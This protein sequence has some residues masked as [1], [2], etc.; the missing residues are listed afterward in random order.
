MNYNRNTGF[1]YF[2]Q[3]LS[4][5]GTLEALEDLLGGGAGAGARGGS[6]SSMMSGTG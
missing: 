6:G 2:F 5:S 3:I 1:N 4:R